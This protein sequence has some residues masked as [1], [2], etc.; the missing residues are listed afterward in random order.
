MGVGAPLGFLVSL[1]TTLAACQAK[2]LSLKAGDRGAVQIRRTCVVWRRSQFA[3]WVVAVMP[4]VESTC[5]GLLLGAAAVV[6]LL[7]VGCAVVR[8]RSCEK[9]PSRC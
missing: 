5:R 1:A 2:L 6:G 7:Q 4:Y 8:T 9:R 3:N